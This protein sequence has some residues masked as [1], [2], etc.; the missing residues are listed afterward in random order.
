[1]PTTAPRHTAA[2]VLAKY[3]TDP[4]TRTASGHDIQVAFT[5]H[6]RFDLHSPRTPAWIVISY[7]VPIMG[8]MSSTPSIED[9]MSVFDDK[10]VH[11]MVIIQTLPTRCS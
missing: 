3:R 10:N 6:S 5:D 1:V 8:S 7:N 9:E 4:A 11:S 2:E